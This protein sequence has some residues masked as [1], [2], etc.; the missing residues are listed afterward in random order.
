MFIQVYPII[1]EKFFLSVHMYKKVKCI[2]FPDWGTYYSPF[3]GANMP[4][5]PDIKNACVL[6]MSMTSNLSRVYL[7]F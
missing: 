1:N 6:A 5:D 7:A 3:E 4:K 2:C